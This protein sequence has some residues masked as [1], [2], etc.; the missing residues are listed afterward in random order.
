[1]WVLLSQKNG[2]NQQSIALARSIG[3]PYEIKR[4]DWQ[5]NR[6]QEREISKALLAD[7]ADADQ[8]RRRLGLSEPWPAGVIC[9][10]RR[11]E[12]FAMWIKR[13]SQCR[14]KVLKIGRASRSLQSYDLLLATPQFPVPPLPNVVK[15]RFPPL[16][17]V[18]EKLADRAR[19]S[20]ELLQT[21][22]KPWFSILLGGEIRQFDASSDALLAAM[23]RIQSAADLSGGSVLITTSRRTPVELLN[24][25]LAGLT[26]NPYIYRWSADGTADNPYSALLMESAVVFITAD[27][28]SMLMDSVSFGAPTYVLELPER[29]NLLG[30]WEKAVHGG[31]NGLASWNAKVG[32]TVVSRKIHLA[33]DWLHHRGIVRFPK[34][35][36][37]LHRALYDAGLA[38]P[39]RE[40]DPA[41]PL[42]ARRERDVA[43]LSVFEMDRIGGICRQLLER[44]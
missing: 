42:P 8:Q 35:T 43:S 5:A 26:R 1:M 44:A 13:V 20:K 19:A 2:D 16:P 14:T 15:M 41:A 32:L 12:R 11:P 23:H 37:L 17:A 4:L 36:R 34:D 30:R 29:A 22:P 39:A 25:V 27:S 24:V 3:L 9:C 33:Q 31:L 21:F 28:I 10:G 38:R 6:V 7:T 40:F 18:D